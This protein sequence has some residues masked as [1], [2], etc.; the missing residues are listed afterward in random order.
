MYLEWFEGE[1]VSGLMSLWAQQIALTPIVPMHYSDSPF[2]LVL[3]R[4]RARNIRVGPTLP[5]L[6][7]PSLT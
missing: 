7:T 4:L 2:R 6:K 1:K 5:D 3:I